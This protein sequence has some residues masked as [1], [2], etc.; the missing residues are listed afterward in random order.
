MIALAAHTANSGLGSL[1]ATLPAIADLDLEATV[2]RVAGWGANTALYR[3]FLATGLAAETPSVASARAIAAVAGWRSGVVDLRD[4]AL[5]RAVELSAPVASAALGLEAAQLSSFLEGQATDPFAWPTSD[6][7]VARIGGFRG[8]GGVWI[9]A[10]TK[11]AFV[12][13]NAVE[14]MCNDER[15]IAVVDVF[16]AR[17]TRAERSSPAATATARALVSEN[18]YLVDIAR[19]SA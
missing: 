8:C 18:S 17:I 15:W 9:A 1:D 7:L 11:A 5:M 13:P 12:A 14:V 2:D 19:V 6:A 10:P 3:H 16:G 4:E